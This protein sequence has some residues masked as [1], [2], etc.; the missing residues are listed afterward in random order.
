[1]WY[2]VISQP[3]TRQSTGDQG[4]AIV[5]PEEIAVALCGIMLHYGVIPEGVGRVKGGVAAVLAAFGRA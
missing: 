3:G 4:G 2:G 1:M 5:E